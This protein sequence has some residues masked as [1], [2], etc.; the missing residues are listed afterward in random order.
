ME[1]FRE[2]G[3]LRYPPRRL[4]V[5]KVRGRSHK[6]LNQDFW[7]PLSK[8]HEVV[9]GPC[10]SHGEGDVH[11]GNLTGRPTSVML[12]HPIGE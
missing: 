3:Q 4:S 8:W 2:K 9:R 7:V 6:V 12:H 5:V 1:K 10:I 11:R